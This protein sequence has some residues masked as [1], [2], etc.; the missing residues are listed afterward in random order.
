MLSRQI[1]FSILLIYF[2]SLLTC[3]KYFYIVTMK[4]DNQLHIMCPCA[5]HVIFLWGSVVARI[6]LLKTSSLPRSPLLVVPD[7]RV[8]VYF[9]PPWCELVHRTLF[10]QRNVSSCDMYRGFTH[11]SIRSALLSFC[12][13][14]VKTM[15]WAAHQSQ[16][17]EWCQLNWSANFHRSGLH[18]PKSSWPANAEEVKISYMTD[19]LSLFAWQQEKAMATHSST[20]AWKNPMDGE[21]W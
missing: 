4:L 21:A 2:Y 1:F 12:Y 13:H 19:V 16:R 7:I 6:L 11:F 14:L 8:G 20:L 5:F 9:L 3:K 15:S 10:G 17:T 18:R